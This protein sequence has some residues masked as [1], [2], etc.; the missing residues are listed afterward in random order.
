MHSQRMLP[1][2]FVYYIYCPILS[3]D[4]IACLNTNYARGPITYINSYATII[5][6]HV[7]CR[8]CVLANESV[9]ANFLNL[10]LAVINTF[11]KLYIKKADYDKMYWRVHHERDRYSFRDGVKW[12]DKID[13]LV[14]AGRLIVT[15]SPPPTVPLMIR[16]ERPSRS[17]HLSRLETF[18]IRRVYYIN[19]MPKD[20]EMVDIYL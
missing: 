12:S 14:R 7:P 15:S 8:D 11:G 2:G 10:P 5:K 16:D 3:D 19:I 9:F 1:T 20:T 6:N 4:E 17:I 18:P 13:H